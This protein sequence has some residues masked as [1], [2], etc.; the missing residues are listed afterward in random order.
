MIS[1][2]SPASRRSR[3]KSSHEPF[4]HSGCAISAATVTMPRLAERD[5]RVSSAATGPLAYL[6]SAGATVLMSSEMHTVQ[7]L[8]C[9]V[10]RVR[11]KLAWG[12]AATLNFGRSSTRYP[13]FL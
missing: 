6:S 9:E 7:F 10:R 5:L 1:E 11:T 8:S 12:P 2:S 13:G 3:A 4:R